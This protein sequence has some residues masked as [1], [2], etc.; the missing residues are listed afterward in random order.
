VKRVAASAAAEKFMA[1][2]RMD[3]G[4]FHW[5]MIDE[6]YGRDQECEQSAGSHLDSLSGLT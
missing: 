1:S 6:A 4:L 3:R 5:P 2:I